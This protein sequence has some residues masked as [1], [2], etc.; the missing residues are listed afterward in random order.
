MLRR[1]VLASGLLLISIAV[2]SAQRR[3]GGGQ[4]DGLAFRFLGPAVGN[5]VAPIAAVPPDPLTYYAGAPS[6]RVWKTTDRPVRWT[7]LPSSMPGAAIAPLGVTPPHAR[8]R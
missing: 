1:T 6:G 5:R 2:L 7:P 4:P 3:G 8:I